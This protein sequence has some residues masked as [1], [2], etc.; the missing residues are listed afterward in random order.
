MQ[1]MRHTQTHTRTSG[2]VELP[3]AKGGCNVPGQTDVTQVSYMNNS[4]VSTLSHSSFVEQ[5]SCTIMRTL[6]QFDTN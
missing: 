5:Y 4:S 2:N 3:D 1:C 6:R